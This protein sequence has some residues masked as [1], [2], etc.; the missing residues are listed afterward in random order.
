M[1]SGRLTLEVVGIDD[2][3]S[4]I[5]CLTL[6]A[7]DR[8]PLPAFTPGSHLVVECGRGERDVRANAYSLTGES[9]EPA[10]YRISVLRVPDGHGGS[11]WLHDAVAVGDRVTA[12]LPRSGFAPVVRARHHLL[13]AG[14]I[15]IT[16]ML[17]H[18]RAARAW[19]RSVQVLY[20]H[21]AGAGAHL[22]EVAELT[23]GAAE[24]F[25]GRRTFLARVRAALAEQPIGTHLYLCG[26]PAMIDDVAASAIDLGWPRSRVHLERFTLGDLDPGE[27]FRVALSRTGTTI[28]V[29][30]GTS[31][32]DAL[33]RAGLSV[34]NLCR[35]GV[36]GECR[37]PLSAGAPLHRDLYLSEEERQA[38][39]VLMP[40]VSR[41]AGPLLEV[42]L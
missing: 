38:G 7:P 8:S 4:G 33:E 26:P 31:L 16:P 40:C 23:D 34:P 29:P 2:G 24:T 36:C 32:L 27:P 5:R 42:S 20:A 3:V 21:R 22:A 1:T 18:L 25:V 14:G 11:A 39:D 35:Q 6:A 37:I 41:A 13:V 19:G 10:T 12:R 17:S 15:G 9:V 28:D 30:S